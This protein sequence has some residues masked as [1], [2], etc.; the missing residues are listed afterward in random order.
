MLFIPLTS[1][2]RLVSDRGTLPLYYG[3][4]GNQ[5]KENIYDSICR[6][7]ID[8]QYVPCV[9]PEGVFNIDLGTCNCVAGFVFKELHPQLKIIMLYSQVLT[10]NKLTRVTNFQ[11]RLKFCMYH[12]THFVFSGDVQ[13]THLV[14]VPLQLCCKPR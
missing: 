2:D 3:C 9:I 10:R 14:R 11:T 6:W 4:C 8:P 12:Q 13:G 1:I 5:H 7:L